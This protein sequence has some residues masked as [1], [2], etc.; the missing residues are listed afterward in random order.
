MELVRGSPAQGRCHREERHPQD[1]GGGRGEP[2]VRTD[3]SLSPA[4]PKSRSSPLAL[5]KHTVVQNHLHYF[6]T[7][8]TPST[9]TMTS[10]PV[11]TWQVKNN[12][13]YTTTTLEPRID[14]FRFMY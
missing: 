9:T 11:S 4:E 12:V 6:S 10:S 3:L 13:S 2:Q 7:G 1:P 14:L 5:I 8:P